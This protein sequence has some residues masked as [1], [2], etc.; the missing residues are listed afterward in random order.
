MKRNFSEFDCVHYIHRGKVK[1]GDKI[2]GNY[3]EAQLERNNLSLASE[4]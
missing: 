1:E 3:R 4:R 2:A